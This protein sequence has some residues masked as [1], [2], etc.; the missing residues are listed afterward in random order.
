MSNSTPV[1]NY[2]TPMIPA[3][4]DIKAATDFYEQKLGFTTTYKADD[5]SMVILQRGTVNIILQDHDDPQTASQTSFRIELSVV[6]ALYSEYQ[7]KSIQ[8]FHIPDG[9][10]L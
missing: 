10:G 2:V 5:F 6:D 4:K 8:P 9:A 7:A 1:L 3:G